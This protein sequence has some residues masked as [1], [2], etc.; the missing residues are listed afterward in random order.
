MIRTIKT[1]DKGDHTLVVDATS[2][3]R[4]VSKL[5]KGGKTTAK[6]TK[7]APRSAPVERLGDKVGSALAAVGVTT[8]R[9]KALKAA[10]GLPP[11]CNC[12]ARREWLNRLDER[13]GLADKLA[14]VKERLG[15]KD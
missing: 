5:P 13:L 14:S 12:P 6:P 3:E 4:V 10:I 1:F 9:W 15:W 2:G 11:T 7:R 8:E